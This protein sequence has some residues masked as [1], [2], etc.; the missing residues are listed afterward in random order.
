MSPVEDPALERTAE[1]LAGSRRGVAFTGAGISAE[2]GIPVFR[3]EGGLWTTMDPYRVAS[4]AQFRKD[5][6]AY[7][8]YSLENRRTGA[9][10]NPAHRALKALEDAGII[11]AVITQNTDGL[12]QKA[13]SGD[14][15]ELHGSSSRVVC[16][17]CAGEFPREEID[18]I[19]RAQTPP[20]C[21]GCGGTYLKPTVVL[22]GESLPPQALYRAEVE[23]ESADL[24]LV[25]GSSLQ[26]Y[27]A[28]G[29]PE[30]ALEQGASLCIV[31]AEA[32]PL[33]ARAQAVVTGKAGEILPRIAIRAAALRAAAAA[34]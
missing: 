3:G 15:I 26:V 31:N 21:P 16:F 25:V 4:I 14:V 33:D 23:A 18:R 6:G 19:N 30:K 28:A 29:I 5:P 34:G 2:S 32:T 24:M 22:F 11:Q 20:P 9:E 8:R 27:P 12:H 13:G 7:W 1:L 10:P 17:D